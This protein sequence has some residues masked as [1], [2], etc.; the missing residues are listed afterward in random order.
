MFVLVLEVAFSYFFYG[1]L[2][3]FL[4]QRCFLIIF[5]SEEYNF[6]F[7]FPNN[8]V[9][10]ISVPVLRSPSSLL[11][12]LLQLLESVSI[13]VHKAQNEVKHWTDT[14]S[15]AILSGISLRICFSMIHEQTTATCLPTN[16]L[17]LQK[18]WK[19]AKIASTM[20]LLLPAIKISFDWIISLTTYI[21]VHNTTQITESSILS[22]SVYY[23]NVSKLKNQHALFTPSSLCIKNC[24]FVPDLSS[25]MEEI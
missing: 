20:L 21:T 17:F 8:T 16:C 18:C 25:E 7:P 24:W 6:P 23:V 12:F 11:W 4:L 2:L 15:A 22:H 9:T 1:V 13:N 5:L 14:G 10:H 19:C 3:F